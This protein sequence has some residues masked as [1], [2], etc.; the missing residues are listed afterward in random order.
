M[1]AC[2]CCR[3]VV[4]AHKV[5]DCC[6]CSKNFN[7]DCVKITTA[8]ARRIHLKT[9]IT[10]TCKNCL[11]LGNDLNSLKSVIVSLQDEIRV[12]KETV[13]TSPPSASTSLLETEKVI[14]EIAD[15]ERRKTNIMIFRCKEARCENIKEQ[16]DLDTSLVN[17]IC[18]TIQ[19]SATVS[20]VLRLGKYDSSKTSNARPI[21]VVFSNES[22]VSDIIR[23]INKLK[24]NPKFSSLSISRDKTPMQMEIHK[25]AKLELQNRIKAGE[26][27]LK[28]KYTKGVPSVI[29]SLN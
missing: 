10:W 28:I 21:K 27:N 15:R 20:K 12:L 5:V 11:Q 25:L 22:S 29:S 9:G 18:A 8:E 13:L 17:D 26:S 6:V 16:I 2:A 3:A 7:I 14:Q 1:P 19:I 4:E 23:N 24:S